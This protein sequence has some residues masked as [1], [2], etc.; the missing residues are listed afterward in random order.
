MHASVAS[1]QS[2]FSS[3]REFSAAEMHYVFLQLINFKL[4]SRLLLMV[5][6]KIQYPAL[7]LQ[8]PILCVI[9]PRFTFQLYSSQPLFTVFDVSYVN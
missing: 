5:F 4:I 8:T 7:P 6:R 3:E 9:R 1:V 2:P